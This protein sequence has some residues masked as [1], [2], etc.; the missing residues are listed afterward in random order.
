[1][2]KRAF[3]LIEMCIVLAI[4]LILAA[5]L[6]GVIG[7]LREKGRQATCQSNLHQLYLGLTQYVSDNDSHFPN[8]F[9][10]EGL[11]SYTKNEGVFFCP[12]VSRPDDL[13][14]NIVDEGSDY[15]FG[16]WWLSTLSFIPSNNGLPTPKLTGINEA[17]TLDISTLPVFGDVPV[18]REQK[19]VS[20]P[21]G[22]GCGWTD[23]FGK[24][25]TATHYST[26]HSG[27]LNIQFYDGHV[28]WLAPEKAAE[29]SCDLGQ[30]AQ[31]PFRMGGQHL[32]RGQ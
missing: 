11:L 24:P 16:Y 25:T 6:M 12:N 10:K 13:D 2:K 31:P 15:Y 3:T 14:P 4:I 23:A 7:R 27:G 5:L 19:L 21:R 1:M 26:R 29:V 17:A 28:K 18:N 8:R 30:Y 9:W 32:A 22:V 20:L